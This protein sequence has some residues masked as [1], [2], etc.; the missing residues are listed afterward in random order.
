VVAV[1]ADVLG[2]QPAASTPMDEESASAAS[3]ATVVQIFIVD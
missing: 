3:N 1:G 2:L